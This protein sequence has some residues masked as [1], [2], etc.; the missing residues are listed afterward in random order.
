MVRGLICT[1]LR[2]E[3]R[4]INTITADSSNES[5]MTHDDFLDSGRLARLTHESE[6]YDMATHTHQVSPGYIF[7]EGLNLNWTHS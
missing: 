4:K 6:K 2:V 1:G 5:A 7:G 3:S